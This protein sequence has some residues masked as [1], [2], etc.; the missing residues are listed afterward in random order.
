[1]KS[2]VKNKIKKQVGSGK[3]S[4]RKIKKRKTSVKRLEEKPPVPF[5][6]N[7]LYQESALISS[8]ECEMISNLIP[9]EATHSSLDLFE[10]PPLL[11][12]FENAFTQKIGPSYLPDCPMLE[13][14]VLGDRN[15]FIDLQRTRLEIML[16][17]VQNNGNVIRT[18]ATDAGL[19][20]TPLLVN[21]PLSFCFPNARCL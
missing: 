9:T 3:K 11:V 6:R 14:E 17:V 20:D 4:A 16:R 8:P 12:T 21:N 13:F 19:R 1:M 2:T 18:H 5:Q 7:E 15:N 10:K